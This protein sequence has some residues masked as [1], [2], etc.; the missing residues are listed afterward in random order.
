MRF[1]IL[2]LRK[3]LPVYALTD[4][5]PGCSRRLLFC[6]CDTFHPLWFVLP[7]QARLGVP[8]GRHPA[9]LHPVLLHDVLHKR[10]GRQ[11]GWAG[12]AGLYAAL[13]ANRRA[14][15]IPRGKCLIWPTR[16]AASFLSSTLPLR[17][18]L[19]MSDARSVLLTGMFVP[20]LAVGAVGGRLAGRFV[21]FLVKLAGSQLPV[22]LTAYSVIGG[23]ACMHGGRP[24]PG[25]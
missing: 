13:S 1:L 7:L 12:P 19:L 11:H 5:L 8:S 18:R 24:K 10:R 9:F 3:C 6:R 20:S 23:W 21:A 25:T 14:C 4:P 2:Q 15:S 16:R 17:V 22:S